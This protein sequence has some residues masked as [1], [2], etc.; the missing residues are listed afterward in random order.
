MVDFIY[1]ASISWVLFLAFYI[2]FLKR[3]TFY[4]ANRWYLLITLGASLLIPFLKKFINWT[5]NSQGG[6]SLLEPIVVYL[7]S[8]NDF[9]ATS[10]VAGF[11]IIPI[12]LT[13]LY[14]IG[15]LFFFS[16]F[17]IELWRIYR[18]YKTAQKEFSRSYTLVRTQGNH[19][20]FSFF[21]MVF[22]GHQFDLDEVARDTILKHEL[23]HVKDGHTI[24]VLLVELIRIVFWFHPLV[25]IYK[26]LI[27]NNHEFIADQG[28]LKEES[29]SNYGTLLL[30]QHIPKLQLALTHTF[31]KTHLKT[32]IMMMKKKRSGKSNLLKYA[33][34]VP[35]I[36][37]ITF[38]FAHHKLTPVSHEAEIRPGYDLANTDPYKVVEEMPRFPGCED[39]KDMVKRKNCS[40]GKLV[41]FIQASLDYPEEAKKNNIS[42]TV[43]VKFVV[44][45]TGSIEQTEVVKNIGGGCG[46]LAKEIIESMP[47]WIPGK[48]KGKKADVEMHLPIKFELPGS[49]GLGQTDD[50]LPEPPSPPSPIRNA[51]EAPPSPPTPPTEIFKIV[52]EMPYFPGVENFTGSKEE[53]RATSNQKLLSFIYKNIKYPKEAAKLGVEGTA[54]I[55]FVVDR[56]GYITD[57]KIVRNVE[58]GCGTEALRVIN[59][60]NEEAGSWE[61]GKQRGAAVNVVYNVPIKFKLAPKDEAESNSGENNLGLVN[62]DLSPNPANNILHVEFQAPMNEVSLQIFSMEAKSVKSM[63]LS[64]PDG[65]YAEDISIADLQS[66]TYLVQIIHG[67]RHTGKSFVKK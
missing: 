27:T 29:L 30:T 24:D 51:P 53:K 41:E 25:Y 5:H 19:P 14:L 23:I 9:M 32:R 2:L 43:V 1:T 47:N 11:G 20:P 6:D 42:G 34:L 64:S 7:N 21:N 65:R 59:L 15:M 17:T 66:G 38:L 52:E 36:G 54:V 4:K 57:P 13:V 18:L 63:S 26:Y 39:Q 61:P 56:E 60:M 31:F 44:T 49:Q 50:K 48:Q 46:E 10:E 16:K 40:L 62:F 3:L 35:L 55:Q 67:D 8:T 33:L 12:L 37:L 45:K 22:Y 58:A 28:V